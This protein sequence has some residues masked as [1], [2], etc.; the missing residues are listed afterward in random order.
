MGVFLALPQTRLAQRKRNRRFKRCIRIRLDDDRRRIGRH[1]PQWFTT[2]YFSPCRGDGPFDVVQES[3]DAGHTIRLG[4]TVWWQDSS[5]RALVRFLLFKSIVGLFY[6]FPSSLLASSR[7][8]L[9][10]ILIE[11]KTHYEE[12]RMNLIGV[13]SPDQRN[14]WQLLG[15]RPKRS[16][17]SIIL[18]PGMKDILVEDAKS[19]LASRAWYAARGIPFRRGYLLVS[20]VT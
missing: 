18:D 8:V 9:N 20:C 2:A 3:L 15:A 11:A 19:F 7:S 5:Y 17:N 16:L 13:F 12:A 10:D 1:G 6:L 14:S 4:K